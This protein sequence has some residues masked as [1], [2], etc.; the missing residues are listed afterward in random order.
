MEGIIADLHIHSRYSRA[1]SKDLSIENLVKY[2]KIKGVSLLGTGDF[3]H[4]LW[5]LEIKQKLKTTGNGI[6][7]Y[8]DFPFVL[9]SEISLVF[10]DNGKGRRVHL[11]LLAPSLE[12]V[13]QI[14]SYL[15]KKG[16]LDYDGRPIFGISCEEFAHDLFSISKDIEIIPAHAWTPWFGVF[17]SMS[18]FDALKDAFKSQAKNIHAIETG[19]SS[20]PAMNWRIS[21][22]NDRTIV[23]FSDAHSFWPF[24]LGREATI[25]DIE[26]DK[27][28]YN[29]MISQI[30]ENSISGTIETSPPYGKYHYDG[31]RACN[32]SCSPKEAKKINNICPV[33]NKPLTIGVEHRVEE[34]ADKPE[35]FKPSNAKNFYSLLPLQEVISMIKG[36]SVGSLRVWNE[37]NKMINAFGNELDILLSV[38]HGNL[39]RVTEEKIADAIISNR[40]GKIKVLPGYDG[41]YGK[42]TLTDT[43]KRLF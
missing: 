26:K 7:Y 12:I 22:L 29:K 36:V 10:S 20:D 25:F 32:F 42:A 28:T 33:C 24:R 3:T 11:L 19:M 13:E 1:T 37:Y 21:E 41:V 16:R 18:G 43:Q 15:L 27:L 35:G 6:Y 5:L 40:N 2:S 9:S 8:E 30:R 34:I 38:E 17:G 31:H 23:S 4:P 14:R 39:A